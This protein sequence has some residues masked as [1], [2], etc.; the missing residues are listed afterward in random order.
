MIGLVLSLLI[1]AAPGDQGRYVMSVGG[2]PV[3]VVSFSVNNGQY[4]YQST[5]VFRSKTRD[6]RTVRSLADEPKPEVWWL[7]RK[8][9]PGCAT[10]FEE[11]ARV[12]EEVCLAV[13]G[14]TIAGTAFQA[15][16]DDAGAL[17]RLEVASVRFEASEAPL[18]ARADPF[19]QGFAVSG[20]GAGPGSLRVEPASPGVAEVSVAPLGGYGPDDDDPRSCL[21]LARAEVAKS[22]GSVMLGLIIEGDRAWPHAWVKT[23]KGALVDPSAPVRRATRQ[24]LAFSRDAGRLYLELLASRRRVIRGR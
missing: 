4:L 13:G 2:L 12:T 18:P 23:S 5:Q 19:A 16:Y 21:E 3:G 7:S 17:T 9:A 1:S 6:L 15:E 11:R 20:A 22:S 10:V 24:Y 8:R 14:G